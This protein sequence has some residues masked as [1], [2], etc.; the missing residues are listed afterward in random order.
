[1]SKRYTYSRAFHSNHGQEVFTAVEF[2]SFDEA[3]KAV[4]KGIYDRKLELS[5]NLGTGLQGS[6]QKVPG[7]QRDDLTPGGPLPSSNGPSSV[8]PGSK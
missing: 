6:V 1:M 4:D 3:I 5:K 8:F 7:L 2:D